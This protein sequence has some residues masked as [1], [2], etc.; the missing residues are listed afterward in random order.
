MSEPR[1]P[2][3]RAA[4]LKQDLETMTYGQSEKNK[5]LTEEEGGNKENFLLNEG[6]RSLAALHTGS[7]N[8][9]EESNTQT[10]KIT[11]PESVRADTVGDL[12]KSIDTVQADIPLSS[13]QNLLNSALE[14]E[15]Q[16]ESSFLSD[17]H[18]ESNVSQPS[19][20]LLETTDFSTQPRILD[21]TADEE[22]QKT[23]S[24]QQPTEVDITQQVP[25]A[26]QNDTK[27][28]DDII[29]SA[30]HSLGLSN[31]N[32]GEDASIGDVVGTI[33]AVDPESGSLSYSLSDD[34]SGMFTI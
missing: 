5:P 7:Q 22:F 26:P 29:N 4:A 34:A 32:I 12:E 1:T 17:T 6:D 21:E 8:E 15:E 24:V 23:P 18:Q 25:V 11:D 27:I 16:N 28:D 20:S 19:S 9:H 10:K 14:V 2:T 13:P 30:P 3:E 33:S 31:N